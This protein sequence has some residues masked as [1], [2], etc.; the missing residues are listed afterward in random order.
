MAAES[1]GDVA[2]AKALAN[3]PV[4]LGELLGRAGAGNSVVA[5]GGFTLHRRRPDLDM[6]HISGVLPPLPVLAKSAAGIGFVNWQADADRVVRRVPL[7][8]VV[9]GQVQPSFAIES[10]RVAQSRLNLPD[11]SG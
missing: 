10:L 5:K 3:R 4:V 9:N 7:M 1:E 8:I 2:F 11:Q 6:P